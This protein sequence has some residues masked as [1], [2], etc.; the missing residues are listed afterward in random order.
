MKRVILDTNIYGKIIENM[1]IDFVID[2][3][4]KSGIV[5]Y[6]NDIIRKELRDTSKKKIIVAENKK[7]KIRILLLSI[8]DF[9]IKNRQF[10]VTG[11]LNELADSY[12]IVY[13]KFGGR[14]TQEEIIADFKIVSTATLNKLDIVYSDD[15]KTMLST[16]SIKSYE[17]VNSIKRLETPKFKSYEEFK[18]EISKK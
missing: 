18:K 12:Y 13:K 17:L 10:I 16:E 5:I 7:I 2:N 15:N 8:Y 11:K 6:G 14:K 4:S 9:I 1:D 3:L